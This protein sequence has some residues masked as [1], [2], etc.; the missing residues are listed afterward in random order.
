MLMLSYWSECEER[1]VHQFGGVALVLISVHIPSLSATH[2]RSPSHMLPHYHPHTPPLPVTHSP[3]P[4]HTPPL[5][6]THSPHSL[7]HTPPLPVTHSPTTIHTLP[8][9]LSHTPPPPS[10]TLEVFCFFTHIMHFWHDYAHIPGKRIWYGRCSGNFLERWPALPRA[11]S[12]RCGTFHWF[13]WLTTPPH[14]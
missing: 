9:S 14:W 5:P 6:A 8:H 4:C 12:G 7:P 11:A 10:H 1:C 13:N 3:T 2:S